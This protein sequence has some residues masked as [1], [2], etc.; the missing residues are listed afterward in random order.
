M[1][2]RA[3]LGVINREAAAA[4]AE[5]E[6]EADLRSCVALVGRAPEPL[7]GLRVGLLDAAAG[8]VRDAGSC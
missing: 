7:G 2:H 3:F 1:N 8:V 5:E 4:V 6:G